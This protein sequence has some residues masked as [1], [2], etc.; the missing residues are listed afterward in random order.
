MGPGEPTG[1]YGGPKIFPE[2]MGVACRLEVL[3]KIASMA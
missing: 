1:A 3:E 2:P